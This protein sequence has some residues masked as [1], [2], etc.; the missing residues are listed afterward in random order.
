[1]IVSLTVWSVLGTIQAARFRVVLL[2]KDSLESV[3]CFGFHDSDVSCCQMIVS[4]A[5]IF[6]MFHYAYSADEERL[7]RQVLGPRVPVSWFR[8]LDDVSL[9]LVA[10]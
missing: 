9:D 2:L 10:P 7:Q 1:M 3:T 4:S 6:V 8:N 5:F